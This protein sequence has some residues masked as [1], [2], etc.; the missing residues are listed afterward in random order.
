MVKLYTQF[1]RMDDDFKMLLT[2]Q[3]MVV[4]HG[5]VVWIGDQSK[6]PIS[7]K[8]IKPTR[9]KNQ[10]VLPAF[11]ECHTHTVFSGSRAD[12]FEWR[13]QGM[14]YLD[15]AAKGGGILSTVQKTR[16]ATK[17]EL[18]KT[19]QERV[20][21][22][23]RQGVATLE[24]KSGYGLDLSSEIKMLEVAQQLKGPRIITTFLG[25]HAKPFEFKSYD[26]YLN[27]L[28][29][30]VLPIVKKK[31][32]SKRVDIFIEKNFFE[33]KQSKKFL[34]ACQKMGFDV[35]IHA[36]Q[37]TDSG[38]VDVALDLKARSADHVI[39]LN[40]NH[41][42]RWKK[43]PTV[44]VLLP[45]ADLYMKC[46]Y[47]PARKLIDSGVD[48]ALATDFNPGSCPSQDL[49]LVG[50]LARL[51]MQMTLPEVFQAYTIN[52]AKALGIDHE[53]GLLQSGYRANF[54]V[55][56]AEI[57]DFFYSA[58]FVPKHELYISGKRLKLRT[59]T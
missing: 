22:Y 21:R 6:L 18:V 11:I 51:H 7:F 10:L 41:F 31:K 23:L 34:I 35:V 53:E 42:Q 40:K 14:S 1:K 32:L 55:T 28:L 54:I 15:I 47:P 57:S 29:L 48:V 26:D 8:K 2:N 52:A 25:A 27:Y 4:S 59:T 43:S 13:N 20:N 9:L 44:A 49:M 38:G 19:A 33:S 12:E 46:N 56:G 39:H 45:T 30:K 24:I 5:K 16:L 3:A 58:G 50:L 36:N 37:L 17:A